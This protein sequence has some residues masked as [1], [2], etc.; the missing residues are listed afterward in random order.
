[1]SMSCAE[2]EGEDARLDQLAGGDAV[3]VAGDGVSG[4]DV[5]LGLFDV[6]VASS[7]FASDL[8]SSSLLF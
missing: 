1:V 2:G 6:Y 7:S 8:P 4:V 5:S 3:E